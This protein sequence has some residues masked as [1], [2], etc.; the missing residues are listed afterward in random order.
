MGTFEDV[1]AKSAYYKIRNNALPESAMFAAIETYIKRPLT[2]G[3]KANIRV[4]A[5]KIK[6]GEMSFDE[7]RALYHSKIHSI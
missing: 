7:Y 4:Y 5:D 1:L 3:Q 6:R 2:D